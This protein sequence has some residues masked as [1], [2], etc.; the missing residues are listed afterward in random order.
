MPKYYAIARP[1]RFTFE[2]QALST[3]WTDYNP[4]RF[5]DAI[6]YAAHGEIESAD[7][8]TAQDQDHYGLWPADPI[9]AAIAQHS[10]DL[11]RYFGPAD[12]VAELDQA[13]SADPADLPSNW[14]GLLAARRSSPATFAAI[15]AALYPQS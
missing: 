5:I 1:S 13:E 8:L 11:Y 4:P 2:V 12:I 10:A 3:S 15:L 7:I 9:E 6:N 14:A